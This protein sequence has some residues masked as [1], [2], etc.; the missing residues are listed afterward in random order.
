LLRYLAQNGKLPEARETWRWARAHGFADAE[1]ANGYVS[2]LLRKLRAEEAMGAW[3]DY[4]GARAGDWSNYAFNGGFE[5]PFSGSPLDWK[6]E[7]RE[8][9]EV[10][11]DDTNPDSG[12]WSL[13]IRFDGKHNVTDTGV[14]EAV[15][16]PPGVYRFRARIRTEGL[17]TDQG[18][19]LRILPIEPA[20]ST[21]WTSSQWL[22]ANPWSTVEIPFIVP[23]NGVVYG[24]Q[25]VRNLSL[26]FDSLVA[27]TVWVDTVTVELAHN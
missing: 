24:I 14:K 9:V 7:P 11:R 17:T 10:S 4:L 5:N 12:R 16:L 22:G 1:G 20:Q 6:I 8:G 27:G 2:L 18:I 15:V 21:G 13:R 25:L 19:Q 23:A 26:K 3:K